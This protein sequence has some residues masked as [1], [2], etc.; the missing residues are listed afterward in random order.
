M[1]GEFEKFLNP[2]VDWRQGPFWKKGYAK[3]SKGGN[4]DLIG[5]FEKFLNP[6]VDLQ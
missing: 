3:F 6:R 4:Y 2:R 5:E 1:I